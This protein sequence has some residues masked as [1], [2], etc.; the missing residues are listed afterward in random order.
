MTAA[1]P[2]LAIRWGTDDDSF[3]NSILQADN[4]LCTMSVLPPI[5]WHYGSRFLIFS[6]YSFHSFRFYLFSENRKKLFSREPLVSCADYPL[7]LRELLPV[8]QSWY[9]TVW[10]HIANIKNP[11]VPLYMKSPTIMAWN[12]LAIFLAVG[13][14]GTGG[15]D[16][17]L[18]WFYYFR[19][20]K[21]YP[22][23]FSSLFFL[24]LV[25]LYISLWSTWP[26]KYPQRSFF[27]FW[28]MDEYL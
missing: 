2:Y 22:R 3:I 25:F 14:L 9:T 5:L 7:A 10:C 8:S 17:D 20:V 6:R 21:N 28:W 15:T 16:G 24:Y 11:Y 19:E 27:F 4:G 26:T 12:K 23:I 1:P 18:I 13:M